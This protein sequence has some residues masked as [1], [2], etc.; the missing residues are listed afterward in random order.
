MSFGGD[1]GPNMGNTSA[2]NGRK[3]NTLQLSLCYG[4]FRLPYQDLLCR[5][6]LLITDVQCLTFSPVLRP[7]L[8]HRKPHLPHDT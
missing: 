7:C 8:A 6:W 3:L 1:M 4:E 5:F 2:T